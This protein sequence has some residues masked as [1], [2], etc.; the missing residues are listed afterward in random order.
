MAKSGKGGGKSG[1]GANSRASQ[2]KPFR[3]IS[4]AEAGT[5]F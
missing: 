1:K 2:R 4:Q 5:P 3:A